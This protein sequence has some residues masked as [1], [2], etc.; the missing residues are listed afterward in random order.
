MSASL[1]APT[2]LTLGRAAHSDSW[3]GKWGD[4]WNKKKKKG[5]GNASQ[6]ASIQKKKKKTWYHHHYY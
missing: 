4:G 5:S 6:L 3:D 2:L 1:A